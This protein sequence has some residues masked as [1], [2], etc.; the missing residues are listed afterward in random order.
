MLKTP[1]VLV[2]HLLEPPMK[3]TGITRYLFS[4]LEELV[5]TG[6]YQYVLATTWPREAL[7]EYLRTAALKSFTHPFVESTPLNIATQMAVLPRLMRKTQASIEFNCNPI[8]CFWPFWPRVFTVHDLYFEL[9]PESFPWRHRLW[10]HLFFPRALYAASAMI[11]VSEASRQHLI[12]S[13]PQ[14]ANKSV[15]IHEAGALNSK[16]PVGTANNHMSMPVREMPYVLYVGNISPNKNSS[17][18]VTALKLL[19][20]WGNP[21]RTYHVGRDD[22]GLLAEAQRR[23]PLR[24]PVQSIGPVSDA[25]LAA[26]YDKSYCLVNTSLDEGFCLPILEAQSRGVPIICSD[27]PVLREV[28]GSGAM[29]FNPLDPKSLANSIAK[30]VRDPSL[31][32]DI[33]RLARQNAILFSWTRAASETERVFHDILSS[34]DVR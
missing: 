6:S 11:C 21:V 15:V 2:N 20:E 28:A 22:L 17:A 14:S 24:Y 33:K 25:V 32:S 10:W 1:V 23:V 13:Y 29:F 9:R 34:K 7:P 26:I 30:L 4:I 19:E 16:T 18:L 12:R 31:H 27:I 3:I 8:G 5:A